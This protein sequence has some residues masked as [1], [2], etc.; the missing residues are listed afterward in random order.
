MAVR[1]DV[2]VAVT[3]RVKLAVAVGAGALVNVQVRW[4]P[5]ATVIV[6]E[7]APVVNVPA[8]VQPMPMISHPGGTVSVTV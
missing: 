4:V 2:C 5:D 7:L 8:P 6:T 3:V 1:V